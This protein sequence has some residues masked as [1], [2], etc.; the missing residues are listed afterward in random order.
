[1]KAG[2]SDRTA[3]IDD[4]MTVDRA[5]R[6]VVEVAEGVGVRRVEFRHVKGCID[7]VLQADEDA[8]AAR[9][10]TCRDADRGEN[11]LGTVR[12]ELG[13]TAHRSCHADRLLGMKRHVEEEGCLFQTVRAVRHDE[14]VGFVRECVDGLR[15]REHFLC[16]HPSARNI[17]KFDDVHVCPI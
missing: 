5:K 7:A 13:G 2:V 16:I 15:Q 4:L 14:A 3:A 17:G 9:A 12:R 11:I 1:M 10:V 6:P 8:H